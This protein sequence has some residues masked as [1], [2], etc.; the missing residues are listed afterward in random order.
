MLCVVCSVWCMRECACECVVS[1]VCVV[2]SMCV[3]SVSLCESVCGNVWYVYEVCVASLYVG[4]CVCVYVC[5]CIYPC[6]CTEIR[7]QHW[8]SFLFTL[9]LIFLRQDLKLHPE[10]TDSA[11]PGQ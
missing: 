3:C 9:H 7:S 5:V 11:R 6:V 4:V 10:L 2:C 1:E 8:L